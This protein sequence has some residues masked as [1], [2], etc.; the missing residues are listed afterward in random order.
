MTTHLMTVCGQE[1]TIEVREMS[2]ERK[3]YLGIKCA[4]VLEW[5]HSPFVNLSGNRCSMEWC[6]CF[7]GATEIEAL[8]RAAKTVTGLAVATPKQGGR[9]G[10]I[11]ADG[12]AD[13]I[14]DARRDVGGF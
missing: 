2:A 1:V 12:L 14:S 8:D 10:Y 9:G 3:A 13:Q 7:M 5:R 4:V 6:P 11:F